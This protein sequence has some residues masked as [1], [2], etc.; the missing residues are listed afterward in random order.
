M[1]DMKD[2]FEA[3]EDDRKIRKAERLEK[4]RAAD[5]PGWTRHTE[6][7]WSRMVAGHRLNWWPST[8]KWSYGT[9]NRGGP[10][11]YHGPQ[12]DV[13]AFIRARE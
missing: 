12:E 11:I 8:R 9:N 5:L 1:G 13:L 2:L 4:A 10:R 3:M 7:H 6:Y